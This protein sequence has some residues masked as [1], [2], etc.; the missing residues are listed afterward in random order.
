M[1]ARGWIF[2]LLVALLAGG[3]WWAAKDYRKS[4]QEG[5]KA[6]E[7]TL[8]DRTQKKISLSDYRGS[9]VLVNFWATWCGPC[10]GEMG[11]LERLY[12]KLK[13]QKFE[14]LALSLDEEGWK[15]IEAFTKKVP[16]T[17]PVLLDEDFKVSE[18]YGTYRLPESYLIDGKGH[19][20]EKILGA[21]DWDSEVFVG[22]IKKLLA[23]P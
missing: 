18:S 10:A 21:Q 1:K 2:F 4:P 19:V 9:V 15:A 13:G 3:L 7:F 11:S 17:F 20:V 8:S 12:Q 16:L 5:N 22:K 6:P 14:I 23:A